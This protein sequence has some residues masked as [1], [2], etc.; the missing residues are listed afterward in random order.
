[1]TQVLCMFMTTDIKCHSLR[2]SYDIFKA[3]MTLFEMSLRH[4]DINQYIITCQCL[5]HDNLTLL[6]QHNLL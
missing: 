4:L 6:R 5:C 1:M 3:N 2:V